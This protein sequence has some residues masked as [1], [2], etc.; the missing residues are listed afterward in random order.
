MTDTSGADMVTF[1][2]SASK[3][4]MAETMWF[5]AALDRSYWAKSLSRA[6]TSDLAK[7]AA[8]C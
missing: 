2:F 3:A 5:T 6:L 1:T 4:E 8:P 7:A